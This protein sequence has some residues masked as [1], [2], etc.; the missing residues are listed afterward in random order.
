MIQSGNTIFRDNGFP[1]SALNILLVDD[2][3][4]L[5]ITLCDGL[6]KAIG[7][8]ISVV[9]CFSGFEAQALLALQAFDLVI[10]DFNMPGMSGLELLKKIR[11]GHPDTSLILISAYATEAH[12]EEVDRLGIVYIAK[13][14]EISLLVGPIQDLIRRKRSEIENVR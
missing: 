8:E 7:G 12:L 5:A 2:D 3:R 10:S 6:R 14:F 11:Q 4:N 13:P 1:T 9:C